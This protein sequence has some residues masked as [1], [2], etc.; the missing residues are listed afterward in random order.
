MEDAIED[1]F[2]GLEN[3]LDILLKKQHRRIWRQ[4][5]L[6]DTIQQLKE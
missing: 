6:Q 3:S 2:S 1:L 4:K 5:T